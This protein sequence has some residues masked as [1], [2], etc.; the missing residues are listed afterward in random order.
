MTRRKPGRCCK[1]R[2]GG[3]S[4]DDAGVEVARPGLRNHP[5][6]KT[7]VVMLDGNEAHAIGHLELLWLAAYENGNPII[8][9]AL[10]V[11][12]TAGWH[13][14]KGKLLDALL[15]CGG[16]GRSGFIERTSDASDASDAS[17]VPSVPNIYQVHDLFDHAPEYV[18]GRRHRE[19]ER[20][21]P[22]VC[23]RCG[24]DFKSPRSDAKFCS[25]RC[26]KASWDSKERHPTL[27]VTDRTDKNGSERLVTAC[28][29]PPCSLLPA[30]AP[31]LNTPKPPCPE[32]K[33]VFPKELDTDDF[34]T[35]WAR[36]V[37]HRTQIKKSLKPETISAQLKKLA[38]WGPARAIAAIDY[39][40]F[41]GWQGLYEEKDSDR[42]NQNEKVRPSAPA[43]PS[44]EETRRNMAEQLNEGNHR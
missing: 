1:R 16:P 7:L 4:V 26:R 23:E 28:N 14:D 29:A 30:P 19:G 10:Q 22:K 42:Q 2:R 18:S 40:I 11:E 32:P 13:G 17:S 38:A 27:T 31:V 34:K 36:W 25:T 24:I 33:N 20:E 12:A 37:V 3:R 35:A 44:A 39:T 43:I 15:E 6:F 41:K 5:K 8:G 9:G 21:T